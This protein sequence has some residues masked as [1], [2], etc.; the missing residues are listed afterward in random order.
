MALLR[1]LL[2]EITFFLCKIANL[3]NTEEK[4]TSD[5]SLTDGPCLL[6][7]KSRQRQGQICSKQVKASSELCVFHQDLQFEDKRIKGISVTF[8]IKMSGWLITLSCAILPDESDGK[9][10]NY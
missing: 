4:V 7:L 8:F 1:R 9:I 2:V 10:K 5:G 3:A 6:G